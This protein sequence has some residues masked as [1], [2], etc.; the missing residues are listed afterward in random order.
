MEMALRMLA[1]KDEN[2]R[3]L[4]PSSV[5]WTKIKE[6]IIVLKPL[7]EPP[8]IFQVLNRGM[9]DDSD[10]AT[11]IA[12]ILDPRNKITLFELGEPTTKAINTLK[13]KYSLYYR[14]VPQSRTFIPNE[15]NNTSGRE[16]FYLL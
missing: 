12:T 15:N 11:T 6:T 14:K 4:M 9:L 2:I 8:K 5:A 7:K 10:G 3:D 13:E 1:I 16:Y